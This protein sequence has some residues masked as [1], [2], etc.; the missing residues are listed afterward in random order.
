MRRFLTI[1]ACVL[2]A[3]TGATLTKATAVAQT[4]VPI[5]YIIFASYS[6]D[7]RNADFV[8]PDTDTT[9]SAYGGQ[10][11]RYDVHVAKMFELTDFECLNTNKTDRNW[12]RIVWRYSAASGSAKMGSLDISCRLAREIATA[13]GL[14]KLER[15]TVTYYRAT[16]Q[17]DVPILNITGSKIDKW[18]NFVQRFPF[19]P[20]S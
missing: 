18:L 7:I 14:G 11:R 3:S 8:V 4:E 20:S 15:T 5:K 1:V 16:T 10:L 13:Y 17:I 2:S 19:Q 6:G 12:N 9:V